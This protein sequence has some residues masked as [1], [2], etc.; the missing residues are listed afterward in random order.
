MART[1]QQEEL[2]RN[3][4]GALGAGGRRVTRGDTF[5]CSAGCDGREAAGGEPVTTST[6][7]QTCRFGILYT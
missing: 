4:E 7:V 2:A 6:F 5:T 3:A 1:K